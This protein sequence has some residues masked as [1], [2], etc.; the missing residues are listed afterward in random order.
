MMKCPVKLINLKCIQKQ[1]KGGLQLVLNQIQTMD[2]ANT[3]GCVLHVFTCVTT[4]LHVS[5]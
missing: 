3:V 1:K 5:Y 4:Q 2:N